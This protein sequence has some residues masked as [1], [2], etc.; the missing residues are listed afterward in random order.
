[1]DKTFQY[2]KE[3]IRTLK[4]A[5]YEAYFVG[6]Y[7]RD[8]KLNIPTSD[9]D[10]TT[11]ATIEEIKPLFK[12]VILTGEKYGTVTVLY[13]NH[14]YEIT[15]YRKDGLYKDLRHPEEVTFTKTLKED[16]SRR[17]FTI[18]QLVMDENEHVFD[19]FE[20]LEDLNNKLIRTINNPMERF[21]EDALRL[22]RAFRFIAKLDFTLEEKTAE[23]ISACAPLIQKIAIERIQS[24]LDILLKYP[25]KEK[26]FKA[27]LKTN[28]STHFFNL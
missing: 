21:N 10:I 23:A 28:F 17:D 12:K 20:G 8:Q 3:I 18:N 26:A 27:M 16:L 22:L 6:G 24:E 15:T 1:M 11:S 4:H 14:P 9:I 25:Y 13:N 5:G 19:H 2:G 7:V